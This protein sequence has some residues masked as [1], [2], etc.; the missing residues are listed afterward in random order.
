MGK[1]HGSV[2]ALFSVQLQQFFSYVRG[3]F[4]TNRFLRLLIDRYILAIQ[5]IITHEEHLRYSFLFVAIF[6]T[7]SEALALWSRSQSENNLK[8]KK[9]LK[10]SESHFD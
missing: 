4:V 9:W 8:V 10:Q 7:A 3:V 5:Q 2:I 6:W 1:T